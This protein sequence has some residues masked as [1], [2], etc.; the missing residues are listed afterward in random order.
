MEEEARTWTCAALGVECS[1]D[2]G[3]STPC[4]AASE[5]G[6]LIGQPPRAPQVSGHNQTL[7]LYWL[8]LKDY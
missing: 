1:S 5:A 8:L 7:G 4:T 2:G 3:L 6:W